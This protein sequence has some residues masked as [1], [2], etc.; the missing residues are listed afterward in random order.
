[1]A[2][3]VV[4]AR[5][6]VGLGALSGV[7]AGLAVGFAAG[8][9]WAVLQR[10][11]RLR[12]PRFEELERAR[13]SAE[14]VGR[15]R[16]RRVQPG[17]RWLTPHEVRRI[18]AGEHCA[19]TYMHDGDPEPSWRLMS[20]QAYAEPAGRPA[21]A[22]GGVISQAWA[23]REAGFP[24]GDSVTVVLPYVWCGGARIG[25]SGYSTVNPALWARRR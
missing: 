24:P 10:T 20:V 19:V 2:Q 8:Q 3:Y 14:A 11:G 21:D 7:L 23:Y 17:G 9:S 25:V 4:R 15:A 16:A 5:T 18:Q 1:V 12:S 6:L 22:Y 13:A